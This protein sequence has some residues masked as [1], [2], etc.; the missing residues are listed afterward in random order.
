MLHRVHHSL[1]TR[2]KEKDQTQTS[3]LPS[4]QLYWQLHQLQL[5]T[6]KGR[7]VGGNKIMDLSVLLPDMVGQRIHTAHSGAL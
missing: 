7:K 1:S 2:K 3:T 5:Q 4:D 6:L